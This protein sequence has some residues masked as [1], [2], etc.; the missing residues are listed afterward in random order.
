MRGAPILN[1]VNNIIDRLRFLKQEIVRSGKL[2][3]KACVDKIDPNRNVITVFV[4]NDDCSVYN[5]LIRQRIISA[6][7]KIGEELP[8]N[9]ELKDN[10]CFYD[11][12][13]ED[14]QIESLPKGD[15]WRYDSE[16]EQLFFPYFIDK[17]K[18]KDFDVDDELKEKIIKNSWNYGFIARLRV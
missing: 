13:L 6:T 7:L 18:M 17:E 1:N 8:I 12:Y 14:Y 15:G 2:E 11:C 3:L 10:Y 4:I 5:F 9:V 16:N